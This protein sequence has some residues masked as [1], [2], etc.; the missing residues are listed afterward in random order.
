M[1]KSTEDDNGRA[2]EK[3]VVDRILEFKKIKPTQRCLLQQDRDEYRVLRLNPNLKEKFNKS[4]NEIADFLE[5]KFS[6]NDANFK[7]DRVDDLDDSVIDIVLTRDDEKLS[8][9]L[10]HNNDSLKHNRPYSLIQNGLGF[11]K[12]SLEDKEHRDRLDKICK[13]FR[14]LHPDKKLFRDL[15][16]DAKENLYYKFVNECLISLKKYKN[17]KEAVANWFNFMMGLESKYIKIKVATKGKSQGVFYEDFRDVSVFPEK[18]DLSIYK[19]KRTKTRAASWNIIVDFNN[20]YKFKNRIHNKSSRI[21]SSGQLSMAFDVKFT[22][23][24]IQGKKLI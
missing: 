3:I 13:D 22:D 8:F 7:L 4:A 5:E 21:S 16:F 23:D 15:S 10:K 20:G 6:L 18:M 12:H 14:I 11:K 17:N 1:S 19:G 2:L 24:S 9:S